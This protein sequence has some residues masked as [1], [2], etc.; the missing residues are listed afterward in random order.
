MARTTPLRFTVAPDGNDAWSGT[1]ASRKGRTKD[2]PFAT[3]GRALEAIRERRKAG[4][5]D[6]PAVV[7]LRGGTHRLARPLT[8]TAR[9]SAITFRAHGREKPVL[10]GGIAVSGWKKTVVNGHKAWAAELTDRKPFKQLFVDGERRARTRLPKQGWHGFAGLVGANARTKWNKGQTA[11]RFHEGDIQRWKNLRDVELVAL[12]LW[13]ESHLPIRSVDPKRRI[14]EFDRPSVFKLAMDFSREPGRYVVENILE[15]LEDPGQWY[16]DRRQRTLLYIPRPGE[17]MRK[18][19]VVVPRLPALV[20]VKGASDVAFEGITFAHT[21]WPLPKGQA[22]GPQAASYVPGALTFERAQGCSLRRCTVEHV[23]G[24]AVEFLAGCSNN[25]VDHCTLRDLGAGGVKVWHGAASTTVADCEIGSGGH[26]FHSAVGVLIGQSSHNT[27]VHNHIHDFYY[28]GVSVGWSWGYQPSS[29]HHNSIEWNHIH[30][31]GKGLLSD[32]GG[33]YTLGISPGTR[34]CHNLIHDVASF[35]YGGWGLYT[36]E[37]S[38][39]IL[40]ENNIVYNTRTGGFHQHYGR[41]NIVRNNIFAFARLGQVQR[42]REEDHTSFV[43]ERN[44]VLWREG[45]L[46]H[47]SWKN[48]HW[49]SDHNLAWH[50]GGEAFDFA[51]RTADE[52]QAAGHDVHSLVAD[53][54]FRAPEKGDFRL[55]KGSPAFSLGFQPID[56]SAA[57]PRT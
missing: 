39:G 10:S 49:R 30:H 24:Y 40:L 52:W 17:S 11:A 27:V 29:A 19:Q 46:L 23:G 22:G 21:E 37:G 50:T 8:L 28:T 3:L 20:R 15:A 34:L 12:H 4:E 36:D 33:I 57:G 1:R 14:V 6:R 38:T 32:M 48:G 16:F 56:L 18:T 42:T 45:P 7:S 51:G 13:S 25:A 2:G 44:I 43:F 35:S 47:G 41:D 53:P 54:L 31:L 26:V 5:A 9:D 55:A